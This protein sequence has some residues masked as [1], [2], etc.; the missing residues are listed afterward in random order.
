MELPG[1]ALL[2]MLDGVES[3]IIVDA[4]QAGAPPGTIHHV[5]AE[6]LESFASSSKSAHGWGVAETLRLGF[7]LVPKLKDTEVC[8]IGIE[9]EQYTTGG[10]FS[11]A[12]KEALPRASAAI[13]LQVERLL[14][15]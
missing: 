14:K 7:S 8:V 4:V 3:A 11:R 5:A 15:A 12:V 10:G 13:Q 1:L 9:A 6:Q 2:D